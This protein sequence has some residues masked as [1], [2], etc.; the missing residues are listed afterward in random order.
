MSEAGL[1]H[2][3]AAVVALGSGAAV[4]GGRKGTRRH[5]RLGHL[6]LWSLV[7]VNGTSFLLTD[8]FGGF[9]PFHALALVSLATL[10]AGMVPALV[11]RPRATWLGTHARFMAWSYAGLAA[12]AAAEAA[13][14]LPR[15]PFVAGA[16]IS[17][18]AVVGVA[19]LLI[20]GRGEALVRRAMRSAGAVIPACLLLLWGAAAALAQQG[21]EAEPTGLLARE[22]DRAVL[23]A[24][25]GALRT[26]LERLDR[27]ARSSTGADGLVLHYVG[28]GRY[29]LAELVAGEA[30]RADSLRSAARVALERSLATV[31]LGES[32]AILAL[33]TGL[34]IGRRP[35][36]GV[37]L[38]WRW[39]AELGRAAE[40]APD[41][42]RVALMAGV[43]AYHAPGA[44]GGGL[45][46][47]ERHLAAAIEAF[48][49]DSARA[50]HPAW[51][52]AEAHVWLGRVRERQ[53]RT[54]EAR[55]LYAEALEI[56]PNYVRARRL[57]EATTRRRAPAAGSG[58][59]APS[60]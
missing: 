25:T 6:Y 44:F 11:R 53:G 18:A 2:V 29:R 52:R 46:R 36:K 42:P 17:S 60:P 45:D 47:A 4:L 10:C 31:P 34:E 37:W 38:G 8:L 59:P 22:L 33:L 1:I 55:D 16:V 23:E 41:N 14:R 32:Y 28:Y 19:A 21:M 51:G 15:V 39:S 12:A 3:V 20:H 35:W 26:V 9:G 49:R 57:L 54:S 43:A 13:V 56:S 50:P 30:E 24:D 27:L 5:Q 48:V 7:V 40:L 58:V